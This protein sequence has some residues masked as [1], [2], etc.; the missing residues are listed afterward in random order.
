MLPLMRKRYFILAAVV[1]MQ[2][3]LGAT[4]SWTVFAGQLQKLPNISKTAAQWPASLFFLVFPAMMMFS[5][6][7]L[8]RLGPRGCAIIG[9]LLFGSGWMVASLG[10]HHFAWTLIGI[11]LLSGLG[12]GFA[13]IVPISVGMQWFPRHKGLITG[14]VVAAFGG[15]SFVVS[16]IANHMMSAG[17]S[18]FEMFR[19]FGAIYLLI[20][21]TMSTLIRYPAT[22]EPR[23]VTPVRV[24]AIVSRL[25]FQVLY[26]AMAAGLAAGLAVILNLT[27][28]CPTIS[29]REKVIAVCIVA[30]A[31]ASGRI[32]W[33]FA[34]D[35]LFATTAIRLNLLA[36]ALVMCVAPSLI[37]TP[38]GLCVLAA[39]AGFNY[40]GVLVVYA[41]ETANRW[42]SQH[43]GQIYG[44]LFSSHIIISFVPTLVPHSYKLY[45]SY[46]PAMFTLAAALFAAAI[47]TQPL[48][49]R[50][51]QAIATREISATTGA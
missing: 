18:P 19:M 32:G 34:F 25:D 48:Y 41:S 13:Y 24:G 35:R 3:C 4:Y 47:I 1:L 43:V 42:G 51:D 50:R 9:G 44:W 7:W 5:G 49:R 8:R 27:Q 39:L 16:S 29:D 45:S 2:A 12:V 38:K 46:R 10:Q 6:V 20:I 15:G 23:T 28:L 26:L 30:A 37:S 40:G 33:G 22:Y 21:V 31:N 36:Q 11:G 14:L 17:T